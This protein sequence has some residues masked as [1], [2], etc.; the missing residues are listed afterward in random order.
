MSEERQPEAHA[1]MKEYTTVGI[2]DA[3][4]DQAA[5]IRRNLKLKLP[6]AVIAATALHL[7]AP[8]ITRD[9]GFQKVAGLI[10]VR[11]V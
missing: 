11:M 2:N 3:I 1:F 4:R 8:L 6:D 5:W 9:K 7:K 10:E